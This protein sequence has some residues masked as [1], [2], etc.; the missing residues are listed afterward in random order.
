MVD[1][2]TELPLRYTE[3]APE[4]AEYVNVHMFQP[5]GTPT[6]DNGPP[7]P[8]QSMNGLEVGPSVT[9]ATLPIR[10]RCDCDVGYVMGEN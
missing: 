4:V 1:E 9:M 7:P 6:V 2:H 5:V 10:Y 8:M 3:S